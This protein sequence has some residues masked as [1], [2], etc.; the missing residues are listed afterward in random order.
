MA[1]HLDLG[2]QVPAGDTEPRGSGDKGQKDHN[3][4]LATHVLQIG[5]EGS[6]FQMAIEPG[7]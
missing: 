6:T 1:G 4:E 2:F 7:K 5:M 3:Q